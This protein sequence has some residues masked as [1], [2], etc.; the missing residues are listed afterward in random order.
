[1]T[2]QQSPTDYSKRIPGVAALL[3]TGTGTIEAMEAAGQREACAT[4][5]LPS[6]V[7]DREQWEA[8]GLM[9]GDPFADDS[10]FCPATLPTGWGKAPTDHSMWSNIVDAAGN[11]RGSFFY[12]AAFYDRGAHM[13]SPLTRYIV[14]VDFEREKATGYTVEAVMVKDRTNDE[15]LYKTERSRPEGERRA[16]SD[17]EWKALDDARRAA[18]DDARA[19]LAERFPDH[20]NPA[21]Y[22]PT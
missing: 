6:D 10:L 7:R 13:G 17:A 19:W 22:W 20:A 1:V 18:A 9:F 3:L 21:A 11:V 16:W 15:A 5:S 4:A 12:K 8:L 14:D 2:D